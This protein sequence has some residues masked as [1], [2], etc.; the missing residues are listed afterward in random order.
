MGVGAALRID[1]SCMAAQK[2][3]DKEVLW[4]REFSA[5]R[6]CQRQKPSSRKCLGACFV[7]I[8]ITKVEIFVNF[9]EI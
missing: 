4:L 3:F 1:V 9:G 5:K 2:N 7:Y 6:K 8:P